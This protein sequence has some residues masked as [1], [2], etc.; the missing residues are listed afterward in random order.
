MVS[1]PSR[2]SEPSQAARMRRPARHALVAPGIRIDVEAELGR[3]HHLV[4]NRPQ[5][6]AD[7][8]LVGERAVDLS[9]VEEGDP[10]LLGGAEQGDG[11][12]LRE[13]L[14]IGG[15]QTH[16]AE[17]DGRDLK[18]AAAELA[19][20]HGQSPSTAQGDIGANS[21]PANPTYPRHPGRS[22]A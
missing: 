11:V 3:D 5:R 20:F 8:L 2:F 16:A 18:A 7:Q 6:L 13:A 17:A 12:R 14:A 10:A 15:V 22:E 21:R 4:A 9:R 1:I 19:C